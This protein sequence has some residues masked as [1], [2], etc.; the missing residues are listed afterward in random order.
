MP[1]VAAR[2][3]SQS[4]DAARRTVPVGDRRRRPRRLL[5]G[6]DKA[7]A[8]PDDPSPRSSPSRTSGDSTAPPRSRRSARAA[9]RRALETVGGVSGGSEFKAGGCTVTSQDPP[10]NAK[11]RRGGT[12]TLTLDCDERDWEARDRRRLGD[13][14]RGVPDRL[15][16]RLQAA[17]LALTATGLLNNAGTDLAIDDCKRLNPHDA[18]DANTIPTKRPQDPKAAGRRYGIT[19]GC[20][21][22]FDDQGVDQLDAGDGAAVVTAADCEK[23]TRAPA[24]PPPPTAAARPP[25]PRSTTAVSRRR[26]AATPP[27]SSREYARGGDRTHTPRRARAFKAPVST[28]STTRARSEPSVSMRTT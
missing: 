2:L 25:R 28:S 12:V 15:R 24:K 22:L 10:G 16:R 4:P 17:L 9:S 26:R 14:R 27:A 18:G 21:A 20:A 5:A 1:I 3:R 7:G 19:D 8:G 23:L 11:A 13:V 6:D